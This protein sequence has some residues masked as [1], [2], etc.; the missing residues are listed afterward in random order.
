MGRSIRRDVLIVGAGHS[1][2]A[3]AACLRSKGFAGSILLAGDEPHLP[4]ERP[5]LSKDALLS[6]DTCAPTPLRPDGF[7]KR[8]R[9]EL[10]TGCTVEAIEPD[11]RTARLSDGRSVRFDWCVLATGGRARAL[12]CPGA[13]LAGIHRLRNLDDTRKLRTALAGAERLVVIGA[14]YIG[15]EVAASARQLGKQVDVI[16]TQSRVL[17]R[18]TSRIVSAFIEAQHRAHGVRLHLGHGVAAIEGSDIAGS[19]RASAVVLDDGTRLEADLVLAGIGIDAETGLAE[20][21]GIACHGGVLVDSAFRSSAPGVLAIGDCA[22]HPNDFAGGLWR[23]ESVQHAQDSAGIAADT[24][25]GRAASYHDVPAFWSEQYDLRLQSAGIARDADDLVVRGDTSAGPFSVVYLRE[26]RIIAIDAI[27]A[28]REFIA[29]R[30]LIAERASLD[31]QRLADAD[32]PLR[33]FA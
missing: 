18:V 5:P 27:N 15:L 30:R 32:I 9:I 29:A 12:D 6:G 25:L 13:G 19:D 21:A 10:A 11:T 1:G 8:E 16:E 22:R 33:A 4:Y 17:S 7:W 28:P 14:G 2:A 31:R 3:L 26:G 23:L 20:A 24:I